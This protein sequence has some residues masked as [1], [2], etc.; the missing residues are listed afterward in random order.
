MYDCCNFLIN[1]HNM[2]IH[3]LGQNEDT[4]NNVTMIVTWRQSKQHWSTQGGNI[5]SGLQIESMHI[6]NTQIFGNSILWY[7]LFVKVL[8]GI[9]QY[10]TVEDVKVYTLARLEPTSNYSNQ[11]LPRRLNHSPKVSNIIHIYPWCGS[12]PQT[13]GC[14]T[15]VIPAE[16]KDSI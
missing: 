14:S 12:N 10:L 13:W 2:C 11:F 4:I 6:C 16:L 3:H 1:Y 7:I 8:K 15:L 9:R 5:F